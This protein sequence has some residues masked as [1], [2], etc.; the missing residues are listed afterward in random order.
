MNTYLVNGVELAAVDRGAGLPLLLVHGFP[1]N[2]SLW[3]AQIDGLRRALP[4]RSR[5]TCGGSA[6]A[7]SP[8]AR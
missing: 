2:H 5:P 6:P 3:Q 1:L 7:A 4:R 8:K